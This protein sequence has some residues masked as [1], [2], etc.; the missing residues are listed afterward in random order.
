MQSAN[1]IFYVIGAI[2][3]VLFILLLVNM[4]LMRNKLNRLAKKYKYFMNGEDGGS[5]E[6]RLSTEVR[7][8]REMVSSSEN[9]LHQQ[10]LLATMQ[11]S[12]FQKVGL[13]RYDAFDDTGDKLSFSL[14]VLDGKNNGFILS[15]LAG[16]DTSRIY[17]KQ[18][19]NGQCKEFQPDYYR[20]ANSTHYYRINLTDAKSRKSKKAK[21]DFTELNSL[22]NLAA[23]R[24]TAQEQ[25]KAQEQRK[26]QEQ[27]NALSQKVPEYAPW[28]P[29]GYERM[30]KAE[31]EA[32][33]LVAK[34]KKQVTQDELEGTAAILNRAINTM[35]P[36]NLAELEDLRELS[37]LLRRAGW[38]DEKS[39]KDLK[40]AVNYG[41]MVQKYVTDGSGTHDMIRAAVEKLKKALGQ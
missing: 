32:Q 27:W 9:M 33:K 19:V 13:V 1:M 22:L 12:S 18:I 6:L 24:K 37:G 3:I 25:W 11:L 41:R 40:D 14:T 2:V 39:N 20:N 35:R 16:H 30:L 34:G 17:A 15:S 4:L 10:E 21:L 36:G 28:A 23:E 29:F 38:P 26:A 7:E 5:L 31:A 8:L